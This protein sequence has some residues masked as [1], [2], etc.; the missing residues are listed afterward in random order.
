MFDQSSCRHD[1][2]D[3]PK[4]I[5]NKFNYRVSA[6]FGLN[7]NANAS[8]SEK[9]RSFLLNVLISMRFICIDITATIFFL[10]NNLDDRISFLIAFYQLPA[11]GSNVLAYMYFSWNKYL[12][13]DVFHEIETIVC[14]RIKLVYEGLYENGIRRADIYA[15]WPMISFILIVN[16]NSILM[17]ILDGILGLVKG[18]IHTETWY[19]P[20]LY[21]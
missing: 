1:S 16:L 19:L 14:R 7:L 8:K 4:M 18:D 9:F 21:K 12:A 10:M 20:F 2:S 6:M 17:M 13:N 3:P 11:Y 5:T 15:K